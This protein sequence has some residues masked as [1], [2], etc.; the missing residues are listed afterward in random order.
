MKE[1]TITEKQ[2]QPNKNK[3][4]FHTENGFCFLEK[5]P[6]PWGEGGCEADG[7]GVGCKASVQI[8]QRRTFSHWKLLFICEY[9]HFSREKTLFILDSCLYAKLVKML[10]LKKLFLGDI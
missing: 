1:F 7:W 5:R 10:F 9:I 2:R 6:S 3:G 4:R 8:Q